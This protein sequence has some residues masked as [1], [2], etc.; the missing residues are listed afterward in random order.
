M[1]KA[2]AVLSRPE[3][4]R[5]LFRRQPKKDEQAFLRMR[6]K[7]SRLYACAMGTGGSTCC[8]GARAGP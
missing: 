5:S 2:N 8:S 1:R 3:L 7:E 6:I 4:N